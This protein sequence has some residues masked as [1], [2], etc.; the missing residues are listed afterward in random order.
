MV[1]PDE[2]AAS[3]AAAWTERDATKRRELLES[4]C[5]PGIR[6]LQQGWEHEVVGIDALSN[7][8]HTSVG[9]G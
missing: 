3:Y 9:E 5:G 1:T 6:F 7:D 4:C 8:L 2:L